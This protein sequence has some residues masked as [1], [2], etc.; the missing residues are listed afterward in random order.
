MFAW[1]PVIKN[2]VCCDLS[3]EKQ[4]DCQLEGFKTMLKRKKIAPNTRFEYWGVIPGLFSD[5]PS[6]QEDLEMGEAVVRY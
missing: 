4:N 2:K 3:G 6:Q 5:G 1:S